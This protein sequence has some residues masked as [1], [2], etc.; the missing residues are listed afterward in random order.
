MATG[1]IPILFML[2]TEYY[3]PVYTAPK[4]IESEQ[5]LKENDDHA[6]SILFYNRSYFKVDMEPQPDP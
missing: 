2:K 1:V 6:K 4:K 5:R 3:D